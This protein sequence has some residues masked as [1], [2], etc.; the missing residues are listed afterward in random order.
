[1][2]EIILWF[3]YESCKASKKVIFIIILPLYIFYLSILDRLSII[4]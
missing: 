3:R 1:M 2:V 4:L